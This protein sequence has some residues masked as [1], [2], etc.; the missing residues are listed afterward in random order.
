MSVQDIIGGAQ[1]AIGADPELDSL[2]ASGDYSGW[3]DI[4]G[5]EGGPIA[6]PPVLH[7]A[8]HMVP[9][10]HP[11]HYGPLGFAWGD[12]SR[13]AFMRQLAAKNAALV[14]DRPMNK[15]RELPL[16]FPVATLDAGGTPASP[17]A[18]LSLTQPQV[19]YRGR[20]LFVTPSALGVCIV[21]DLKVGKDSQLVAAEP[22][23]AEM[24]SPLSFGSDMNLD[25]AQVSMIIALYLGNIGSAQISV[26]AGLQGTAVF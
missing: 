13:V 4:I 18:A 14:V 1:I 3:S 19:V 26:T 16:G 25:T 12:P 22:L 5:A 6:P 8:H 11:H 20:R 21:Q 2:L 10:V 7:P 17:T 23:P 15:A 24:F 9:R